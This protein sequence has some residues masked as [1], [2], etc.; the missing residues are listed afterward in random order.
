MLPKELFKAQE[1][2]VMSEFL[3]KV[4]AKKT[5][6]TTTY[7]LSVSKNWRKGP[8]VGYVCWKPF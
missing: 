4:F 5:Q 3:Q 8:L 7:F 2:K 6:F 1:P